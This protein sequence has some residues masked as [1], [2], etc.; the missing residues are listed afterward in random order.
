MKR[1]RIGNPSYI[2]LASLPDGGQEAAV[3]T[4]HALQSQTERVAAGEPLLPVAG[5]LSCRRA[6]CLKVAKRFLGQCLVRPEAGIVGEQG[7][8]RP[9]LGQRLSDAP[10]PV[11][12]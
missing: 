6:R 4:L 7:Y 12:G 10:V 2:I 3:G 9:K 8:R 5:G 11:Q 1:G